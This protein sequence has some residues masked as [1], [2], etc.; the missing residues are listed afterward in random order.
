MRLLRPMLETVL[1]A[2]WVAPLSGLALMSVV[3]QIASADGRNARAATAFYWAVALLDRRTWE[4]LG[5]SVSLAATVTVLGCALSV[6]LTTLAV[7]SGRLARA[8]GTLALVPAL[9]P[10]LCTTLGVRAVAGH[11][12]QILDALGSSW[13]LVALTH[14]LWATAVL[15]LGLQPTVRRLHATAGD[16]ARVLSRGPV[17][18]LRTYRALMRPHIR[19]VLAPR[20]AVVFGLVLFEPTAPLLLGLERSVPV[21]ILDSL[22][23]GANVSVAAILA[24]IAL[25]TVVLVSL[26]LRIS[27]SDSDTAETTVPAQPPSTARAAYVL[28]VV[29]ILAF[30][31]LCAATWLPLA[32]LFP[33]AFP[34]GLTGSS[35]W[36]SLVHSPLDLSRSLIASVSLGAFAATL[37]LAVAGLACQFAGSAPPTA[38]LR[39]IRRCP[40][41]PLA[42]GWLLFLALFSQTPRADSI[43]GLEVSLLS[44]LDPGTA[45]MSGPIV[46][47]AT[48]T[49]L[50][51]PAAFIVFER[52]RG[53]VFDRSRFDAARALGI[54]SLACRW[55]ALDR[56]RIV[57]LLVSWLCLATLAATEASATLVLATPTFRTISP[58]ILE[59][60]DEPGQTGAGAL[61][62][63]LV[64]GPAALAALLTLAAKA[65]NRPWS[66]DARTR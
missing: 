17:S 3:D 53:N 29:A 4:I 9:S 23:A 22:W 2:A 26:I 39:I 8:L 51:L 7:S 25:A 41:L 13:L 63:L 19:D 66:S 45:S 65:T 28:R 58:A 21:Q 5:I 43:G 49:I 48:V 40:P 15:V 59:L 56:R 27:R 30:L 1:L 47:I 12:P 61:L 35:A 6:A 57:S 11:F 34:E 24:L 64:A 10:P 16:L 60:T 62:A 37:A 18:R 54:P 50:L 46:L 20:A 55:R 33:V 52:R 31:A 32:A 42:F 38:V 14:V 44:A 36:S